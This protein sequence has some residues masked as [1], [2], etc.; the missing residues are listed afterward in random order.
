MTTQEMKNKLKKRY[1]AKYKVSN[2]LTR[3]AERYIE[4]QESQPNYVDLVDSVYEKTS[5]KWLEPGIYE[6]YETDFYGYRSE[7][8]FNFKL[9]KGMTKKDL[10]LKLMLDRD[11]INPGGYLEVREYKPDFSIE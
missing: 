2:M 11:Y 9:E 1:T 4:I 5:D 3:L 8:K 6:V 7:T 10:A